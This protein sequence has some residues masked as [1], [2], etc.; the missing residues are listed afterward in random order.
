MSQELM[1][2][3]QRRIALANSSN[4]YSRLLFKNK[5]QLEFP[6]F[7]S[8]ESEKTGDISQI[9]PY[10][11][12]SSKNIVFDFKEETDQ[13]AQQSLLFNLKKILS[14]GDADN[15]VKIL[16]PED[17]KIMNQFFE[18]YLLSI[19]DVKFKTLND[20]KDNIVMF[21]DKITNK[22]S[23][24]NIKEK[25]KAG[26]KA[27]SKASSKAASEAGSETN[28][29]N[30]VSKNKNIEGTIVEK[31]EQLIS[32]L[33]RNIESIDTDSKSTKYLFKY[34]VTLGFEKTSLIQLSN[35]IRNTQSAKAVV[36]ESMTPQQCKNLI[37]NFLE[38]YPHE[39]S[40]LKKKPLKYG[41]GVPLKKPDGKGYQGPIASKQWIS[42]HA[43]QLYV[44][45]DKL[46]NNIL[47]VKYTSNKKKKIELNITENVKM[48]IIQMMLDQFNYN[49]YAVLTESEKK[50]VCYFN[51]MFHLIND[52]VL[53]NPIEELY[54]KFNILRGEINS[55]NDNPLIKNNLK[56]IAFELHKYKKLNSAQIR[57]LFFELG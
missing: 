53:P 7:T 26:S 37:I 11:A 15:V 45:I 33:R 16:A 21:V 39:G 28:I 29:I 46:N 1:M 2:D 27:S 31:R 25:T 17:I 43:R 6:N 54:T 19:K 24:S 35:E 10:S 48:V 38:L 41:R 3:L 18:Q 5:Q 12:P 42:N 32:A 13:E 51:S 9:N 14:V 22:V 23:I 52:K 8:I 30:I 55:S 47:C 57:N 56:E 36:V 50:I 40:G 44:D 34:A 4:A 49:N 20:F